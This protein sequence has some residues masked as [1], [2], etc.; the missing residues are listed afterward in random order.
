MEE[1]KKIIGTNEKKDDVGNA[2]IA[3][4]ECDSV[5]DSLIDNIYERDVK[6]EQMG[7]ET[8]EVG[9]E[10]DV[11][12][13]ILDVQE[14]MGF[15]C[16]RCEKEFSDKSNLSRHIRSQH[17]GVTFACNLCDYKAKQSTNLNYHKKA[18]H[19]DCN[20]FE[21]PN[22]RKTFS[23]R[24]NLQRHIKSQHEGVV[25]PCNVCDYKAKQTTQLKAHIKSKHEEIISNVS[26][27]M[28]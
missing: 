19:S 20:P 2:E 22:C 25:Y 4:V 17:E 9:T 28:E 12:N 24:S 18:K 14:K 21:C 3:D 5:E 11:Q 13:A 15:D 1:S 7:T 10:K 27:L 23:D 26:E 16:N 8:D 6:R